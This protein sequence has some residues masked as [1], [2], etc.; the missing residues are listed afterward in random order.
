MLPKELCE[1]LHDGHLLQP[2][3]ILGAVHQRADWHQSVETS[4]AEWVQAVY[5][6]MILLH[7]LPCLILI[8]E[9]WRLLWKAN[10]TQHAAHVLKNFE[11]DVILKVVEE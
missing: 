4:K 3:P 5:S 11:T 10:W 6:F 7:F 8:L 1:S 2:K 9:D